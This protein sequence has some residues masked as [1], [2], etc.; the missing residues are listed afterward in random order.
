MFPLVATLCVG[1]GCAALIY[2]I[3]WFQMLTLVIGVSSV[4]LGVVLGTFMG[5]M[6]IGS[7][8]VWRL[9][10]ARHHPLRVLACIEVGIGVCGL[11]VLAAMPGINSVYAALASA[12]AA[13]LPGL[14]LRATVAGVCLLPP[15]IL[16]GATLPA[17]ARWMKTTASGVA[18]I[19]LCYGSNI[20]GAVVG[21]L[22]AGFYLLP[23]YDV[24]VASW[25]A[26]TI[27]A[28]V[29]LGALSLALAGETPVPARILP[30][31]AGGTDAVSA[32]APTGEDRQAGQA[33]G[34]GASSGRR[35]AASIWPIYLATGLSGLT[36]LSA[37]V[38]WTRQLALLL[39]A[40]VYTFALVLAVFLFG[41]GVGSSVASAVS[42]H[43]NPRLALGGCQLFLAVAIV[44]AARAITQFLPYW[45]LD[46]TL[47]VRPSVAM[48]LD[49]IRVLWAVLPAALLWGASFPFA[50]AAAAG[51]QDGGRL[52]G[53]L[54]AVNTVGAIVGSLATSF[55]LVVWI[56]AQ[57][58]QQ[59]LIIVAAG[60]ALLMLIPATERF[61]SRARRTA[62]GI[63]I[64]LVAVGSVLT[65]PPLPGLLVAFG[66]FMPT[67]GAGASVLYVDEGLTA[68]IA[69]SRQ[70][71]GTL[72]YHNA[73]KAQ[74]S[75]YPQDMR[76][77]RM[78]GH[79]TTLTSEHGESYLVI[80]L[81]A[82]ITAGAV[83]IDPRVQR[84]VVADIEP[85]TRT[86]AG[87]F[88]REQNFG[89]IG[90]PKVELRVDDGR[91][92]L[93]T[94]REKFDGITSDPLDPWVKGAAALYTR[95]F[96]ELVRSRL[97]PGGVVTV[98]VQLYE[99]TE[100]AVRSELSTFFEEF[101][102]GAVFVNTVLGQGYDAVLLARANDTPIDIDRVES[103]LSRP[104]YEPVSRSLADVGFRSATD[105]FGTY[106]G[107]ASDLGG[108]LD[109]A[110]INTDRNLRLQF[111]AGRGLN[112]NR[113][114][115]IYGNM[116][117]VD[118]VA[119]EDYFSAS[120]ALMNELRQIVR[121]RYGQF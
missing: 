2:Q 96:W 13:G 69:V 102:N 55:V 95:E 9:V 6:C 67:R 88:F 16:I 65:V 25:F 3:V 97:N 74:A 41:L 26:A 115:V 113:A 117:A 53:G 119:P 73:G 27:N 10:S 51:S 111:L 30:A 78:L 40:T 50:L 46:V 15:T 70:M 75:T 18:R 36:A 19:G 62:A 112:L 108:W 103:M 23:F 80:G 42:R 1:S 71:D 68:S 17:V 99:T 104:E 45:P 87:E 21:S 29:A 76:L 8:A 34:R 89:L 31:A 57:H 32:N 44:W 49:L 93:L 59:L 4:S 24:S 81:G 86:A 91:H 14:V 12:D 61:A 37:E 84:V 28:V 43:L 66:R 120:P 39:G 118:P 11:L 58:T 72:T 63:A 54:Y 105:L 121:A 83:A 47:E 98:F 110:V 20:F 116:S 100:E 48:Q 94:T 7:L 107:R 82:G 114:D 64:A 33:G 85:L 101:P 92:F 22:L 38:V 106:A 52:M 35:R 56:G 79:L 5:G 90:D 109:G 77:Q 60:A